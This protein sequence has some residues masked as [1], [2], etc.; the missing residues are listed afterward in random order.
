MHT[1]TVRRATNIA[2]HT[3]PIII[4]SVSVRSGVLLEPENINKMIFDINYLKITVNKTVFV[5]N[6]DQ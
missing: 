2:A 5:T 3:H 1:S 6:S 4:T